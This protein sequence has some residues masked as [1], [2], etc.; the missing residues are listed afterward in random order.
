MKTILVLGAGLSASSLLRYLSERLVSEHWMLKIGN[1]DIEP[2]TAKYGS[3]ERIQ[4]FKLFKS[5]KKS[6]HCISTEIF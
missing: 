5:F 3:N 4:L 2:L 1:T 6:Y